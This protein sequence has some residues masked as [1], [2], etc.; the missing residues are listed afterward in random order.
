L[1]SHAEAMIQARELA[2][3]SEQKFSAEK[4]S[5]PDSFESR[6]AR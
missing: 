6:D 4:Q 1:G 3:S 2:W 5:A